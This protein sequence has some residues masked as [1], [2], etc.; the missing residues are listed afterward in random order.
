[1]KHAARLLIL[2]ALLLIGCVAKS[3]ISI[4]DEVSETKLD[5]TWTLVPVDR[6]MLIPIVCVNE[7][8]CSP[9]PKELYKEML[10]ELAKLRGV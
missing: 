8:N 7:S 10:I 6:G 4:E 3:G 2:A 5:F 1:M 9:L